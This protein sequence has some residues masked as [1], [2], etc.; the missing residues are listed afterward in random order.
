V[1]P[2]AVISDPSARLVKACDAVLD[3]ES[4][5]SIHLST[6]FC[7]CLRPQTWYHRLSLKFAGDLIVECV[8][9]SAADVEWNC[10]L[11]TPG[12]QKRMPATKVQQNL[13]V[14]G[15]E[16]EGKFLTVD[17]AIQR[18]RE[19]PEFLTKFRKATKSDNKIHILK[20]R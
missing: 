5:C 7:K 8:V 6:G 18:G 10:W 4:A 17:E 2:L 19:N 16:L 1:L 20:R 13:D 9:L 15:Y 11:N 12:G 14:E 3:V